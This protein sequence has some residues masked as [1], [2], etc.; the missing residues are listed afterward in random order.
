MDTSFKK[1]N[2]SELAER[3]IAFIIMCSQY[4]FEKEKARKE[5][6]MEGRKEGV[7]Y[8]KKLSSGFRDWY[9]TWP[10]VPV[11]RDAISRCF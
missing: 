10:N 8:R 1:P 11:E 4:L 7:M 6:R 2:R 5:G 9:R 3:A